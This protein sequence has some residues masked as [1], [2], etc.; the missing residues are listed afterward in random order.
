[1]KHTSDEVEFLSPGNIEG[2]GTVMITEKESTIPHFDIIKNDGTKVTIMIED[3]RYLTNDA[4]L[5]P[6]ECEK[7]N[8]WV[9]A[10]APTL[11]HGDPYWARVLM[12]WECL[13]NGTDFEWD[14]TIP[15]YSTI[16]PCKD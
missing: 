14:G 3:N 15:D 2:V 6:N 13:Y 10:E 9:R 7:L 12:F 5:T 8:E 11:L 1:M 16:K 4:T